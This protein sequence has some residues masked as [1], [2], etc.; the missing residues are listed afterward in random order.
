MPYRHAPASTPPTAAANSSAY[1]ILY[2][3]NNITSQRRA[4]FTLKQDLYLSVKQFNQLQPYI[5]NQWSNQG[6]M[7]NK[8]SVNY[9]FKCRFQYKQ[10]LESRGEGIRSRLI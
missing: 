4:F 9:I 6:K 3:P 7:Y 8:Y 10:Q 2:I 1:P 5:I